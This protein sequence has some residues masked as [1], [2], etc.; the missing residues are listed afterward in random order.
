TTTCTKPATTVYVAQGGLLTPCCG[1]STQQPCGSLQAALNS[2]SEGAIIH[3]ASGTYTHSSPVPLLLPHLRLSILG[4]PLHLPPATID[5]SHGPCFQA[6]CPGTSSPPSRL[7]AADPS[8]AAGTGDAVATSVAAE[9]AAE[10]AAAVAA[11]AA[12]GAAVVPVRGEAACSSS[13]VTISRLQVVNGRGKSKGGCMLFQGVT[14]ALSPST[15][16]PPLPFFLPFFSPVLHSPPLPSP[17]TP[18]ETSPSLTAMPPIPLPP[19]LL[20]PNPSTSVSN[21]P[22]ASTYP[23]S[24]ITLSNCHASE[25][26]GG[27]HIS[28]APQP[29]T[30]RHV[31]IQNCSVSLHAPPLN[32][33]A[34]SFRSSANF[35]ASSEPSSDWFS[36]SPLEATPATAAAKGS[37]EGNAA[38][39]AAAA[40]AAAARS[41]AAMAVVAARVAAVKSAAKAATAA[42]AIAT[43]TSAAEAAAPGADVAA[44]API[45]RTGGGLALYHTTATA[46]GLDISG[47]SALGEITARGGGLFVLESSLLL[48]EARIE[49]CYTRADASPAAN[50]GSGGGGTTDGWVSGMEG[51]GEV[52][53]RGGCMA[54]VE[55][56]ISDYMSTFNVSYT[57]F[58][59][60][61]PLHDQSSSGGAISDYMSTFN[62]SYTSFLHSS[63]LHDQSSS[64]GA[65]SD[66]MSTFNVSYTSKW[67]SSR[68]GAI[69]DYMSTF[70]VSYMSFLHS[71]PLHDQ[72]SS[73]GAISDYMS[74]FNVSYT[75]FLHSSP[76]H[77]QS[78]S[79]GAISDYMSTFI[80][81]HTAFLHSSVVY[82][83]VDFMS[84][85][86]GCI[87]LN[88]TAA[89]SFAHCRFAHCSS[90]L[91]GGGVSFFQGE[92]KPQFHNT[93]FEFNEAL[94]QGGGIELVMISGPANFTDCTFRSNRVTNGPSFGAAIISFGVPMRVERSYFWRNVAINM[95]PP[96]SQAATYLTQGGAIAANMFMD[97]TVPYDIIDCTFVENQGGQ[98]GALYADTG[99]LQ[100]FNCLFLRNGDHSECSLGGAMTS[101]AQ[102]V[103]DNCTFVDNK[104]QDQGGALHFLPYKTLN[105]SR[106]RFQGNSVLKQ[107]GGA[108]YVLGGTGAV[109]VESSTFVGNRA[110]QSKGGALY[111][112]SVSVTFDNVTLDGNTAALQGGAVAVY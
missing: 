77:D 16:C 45:R 103:V 97:A 82:Q 62:V 34:S 89:A 26:G 94:I 7:A 43:A 78:S 17:H 111:S 19:P 35:L 104:A 29:V 112:E 46:T 81:S 1:Q 22:P 12:A 69:S 32:K 5:C 68:G 67:R 101:R 31:T 87:H 4:P 79:G 38:R 9:P 73:G 13:L 37:A 27:I 24:D 49:D 66:Y 50:G 65:I 10:A 99:H 71:S 90:P 72:S 83:P 30:L 109:R 92:V 6:L 85:V 40:A 2:A 56:A 41:A 33:S 61:S 48:S 21:S 25:S 42:A 98:G 18:P 59:H 15:L 91:T 96:G 110:E 95:L 74:T 100:V 20:L 47:C 93:T 75:S 3:I 63:P 108:I 86:G 64:G 84:G 70:N 8:G 55:R 23:T 60:S 28:S 88:T 105:V 14:V 36:A 57:S 58:L 102:T 54:I 52:V 80:V 51:G 53:G 76:L 107:N 44:N 11:A 106:S 39:S